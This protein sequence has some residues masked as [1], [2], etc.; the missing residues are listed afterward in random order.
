[1]APIWNVGGTEMVGFGIGS[2]WWKIGR[3]GGECWWHGFCY[4][5]FGVYGLKQQFQIRDFSGW[6]LV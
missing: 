5:S 1:M 2:V 6:L 4:F 3:D